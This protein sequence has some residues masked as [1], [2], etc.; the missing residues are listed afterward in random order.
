MDSFDSRGWWLDQGMA[1]FTLYY[2]YHTGC[3]HGSRC[4]F[5]VAICFIQET[6]LLGCTPSE[7]YEC[8]R[9]RIC[10][11]I[12]LHIAR[13]RGVNERSLPPCYCSHQIPVV[14]QSDC[15]PAA[16]RPVAV[17]SSAPLVRIRVIRHTRVRV[18]VL[19]DP[20]LFLLSFIHAPY[21]LTPAV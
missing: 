7:S 13:V 8:T 15:G 9:S 4:H 11:V 5:Y 6:R 21:L 12:S 20:S 16:A 2:T 3:P 17:V 18:C 10:E 14:L 1:V 19:R